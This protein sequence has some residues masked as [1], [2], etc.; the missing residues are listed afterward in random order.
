[1]EYTCRRGV[2]AP[3]IKPAPLPGRII[4]IHNHLEPSG[5]PE[6][7]IGLMDESSIQTTLVMGMFE[8]PN[9]HVLAAMDAHPGRLVGGVWADPRD[10]QAAIDLVRNYHDGGVRVVK[11]FPNVGYYPDDETFRPFFDV[12]AELGMA[13]LSHCG[14]LMPTAGVTAAYYSQPGRFEKLV[15]TYT[16]TPFIF[17]HMGGISG[18]L[19]AIM[20]ATRAPNVYVDT[21]PGQGAWVLTAAAQ[22]AATIPA[23][24][25]LWGSDSYNQDQW[26]AHNA[27]ALTAVGFGDDF[28]KVFYTNSR[29]LLMKIGALSS[30]E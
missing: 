10:G 30:G 29:D 8:C 22:M 15:R 2:E 11:L 21:S 27:A 20:L 26:L 6:A 9:E 25:I 23:G 18:F 1:M 17:A 24:K 4:D 19:E 16:D 28:E 7:L 3:D 13:V 5:D 12:V 14:W